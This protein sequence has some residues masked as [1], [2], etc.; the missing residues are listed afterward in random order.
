VIRKNHKLKE[1][2]YKDYVSP[3]GE[4]THEKLEGSGMI[5]L[6]ELK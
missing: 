6:S 4:K 1:I 3:N 2:N 5:I